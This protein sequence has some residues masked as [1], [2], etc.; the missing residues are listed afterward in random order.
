MKFFLGKKGGNEM[1]QKDQ[2]EMYVDEEEQLK[3]QINALYN[4]V[5]NLYGSDKLVLR[6][7]KL[8]ALQLIKSDI[9]GERVLAL[10]R[11]IHEDPTFDAIPELQEIPKAVSYPHLSCPCMACF[12]FR[13]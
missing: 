5:V 9:L 11:L 8:N 13:L 2:I 4:L 3:R 7:S 6:A 1:E 10:Q 12:Q